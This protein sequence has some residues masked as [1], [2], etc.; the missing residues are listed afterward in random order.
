MVYRLLDANGLCGYYRLNEHPGIP[1]RV[2]VRTDKFAFLDDP[3]MAASLISFSNEDETHVRLYLPQ[4]H[5]SSCLYLLENLHRL[6]EG[7]ISSR[8]D[9]SA[10]EITVVYDHRRLSL[11]G[12][13]ELLTSLGYE[14]HIS[15]R[16]LGASKPAAKRT[17]VYQ[18]GVAGF[19]FANIMLL[20]FPEY[21][22]LDGSDAVLRR[23]FRSLN[24]LLS[25]PVVLYSAQP[26]Y[27]SAWKSLRHRFLNIDAPIVLAIF[28]TFG[29]SVWELWSG[30]GAG[31]FDSLTG[32][33]FFMLAGR[34]LQDRTYRRLSFD[35]DYTSYFPMA[36]TV[37][38]PVASVKPLPE[39]SPLPVPI[40]ASL[41]QTNFRLFQANVTIR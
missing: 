41:Q 19:C 15:L 38:G 36:V 12:V 14:P 40:C 5:C 1:Q 16:E 7:V 11:R 17:L 39:V 26:F 3:K 34:V 6:K 37:L 27:S 2:A 21:L 22:G 28:V 9:F 10:R 23:V 33:V 20:S 24:F 25:L 13:A 35:R 29:R 4:I 30:A 18:L 8:L 31:Y 32:I